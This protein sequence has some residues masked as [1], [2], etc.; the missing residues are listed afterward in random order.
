MLSKITGVRLSL[1]GQWRN[2]ESYPKEVEVKFRIR[3]K[4]AIVPTGFEPVSEPP[5]GSRIGRYP[6]G[7]YLHSRVGSDPTY[8]CRV[9]R[10]Q[11]TMARIGSVI[12]NGSP[13]YDSERD[14]SYGGEM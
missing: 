3:T 10:P 9:R 5:E 6:R 12:G 7:L 1:G 8:V 2:G 11:P 13:S 4:M 14:I